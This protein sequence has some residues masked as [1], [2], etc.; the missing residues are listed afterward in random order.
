MIWCFE[1]ICHISHFIY[2]YNVIFAHL[3]I[4][5]LKSG[6]DQLFKLGVRKT[7]LSILQFSEI[8]KKR[9]P[10]LTCLVILCFFN[11]RISNSRC[12]RDV[13]NIVQIKTD[14][15]HDTYRDIFI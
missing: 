15:S 2:L 6:N 7:S 1:C 9:I 11:N 3:S 8:T 5:L 4:Q 13:E 12:I 10:I 14:P